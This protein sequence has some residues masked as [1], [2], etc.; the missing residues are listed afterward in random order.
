MNL[1]TNFKVF[2]K[3]V[4]DDETKLT[5]RF[6]FYYSDLRKRFLTESARNYLKRLS[7]KHGIKYDLTIYYCSF[8]VENS[9]IYDNREDLLNAY[10]QFAEQDLLKEMWDGKLI[11][12]RVVSDTVREHMKRRFIINMSKRTPRK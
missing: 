10:D 1:R 8:E 11:P 5:K 9:G 7:F 12:K 6:S 4:N 2:I 3:S